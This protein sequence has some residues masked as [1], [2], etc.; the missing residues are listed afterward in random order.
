L[1]KVKSIKILILATLLFIFFTMGPVSAGRVINQGETVYIGESGLNVTHALNEAQGSPIDG[2][3]PYKI[4]GWWA[5]PA[6]IYITIP[7]VSL[8][9][10][11]RYQN[12]FITA[13]EFTG[14]E[15]PW[16][17]VDISQDYHAVGNPVF[18]VAAAPVRTP[19]FPSTLLPATMII[20]FVGVVL[21]IK[22][23]KEH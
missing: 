6:D 23:T 8:D 16:Y 15:G 3:P 10:D 17:V 20:G 13:A 12:L 11:G 1:V 2:V 9:L 14:Y 5:S 18:V 4:I 7:G 21:Y 22:K 19:E